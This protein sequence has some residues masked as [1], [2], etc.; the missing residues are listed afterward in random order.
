MR[1]DAIPVPRPESGW[2]VPW[3]ELQRFAWIAALSECPQ[4]PIHHAEGNV[5][6]H[7]RMVLEE[8]AR[9]VRW[10]TLSAREREI[11][12]L[13]AVLHD[14]AK[15]STT[16]V[17]ESGR[18]S[19]RGHSRRGAIETRRILWEM[20]Y[21]FAVR[22][23][24]CALVKYHQVPFFLIDE[25]DAMAR[26]ARIS[27]IARCD[28][29]QRVAAAD[30]RGRI[31]ADAERLLHNI[32]LFGLF[33]E[34]HGCLTEP[35]RFASEHARFRYFRDPRRDPGSDVYDDTRCEVVLMC[36]LPGAGKNHWIA[37]HVPELPVVSMDRIRAA[38]SIAPTDDQGAVRKEALEQARG[39]LR[40]GQSFVWNATNLDAQ[41]RDQ[42]IRL[43][44]DYR[45]RVR[46]VYVE[47]SAERLLAQNRSRDAVVPE[48]V[49]QSM[50]RMWQVP[51]PGEAHRVDYVIAED[52][53][54]DA[55]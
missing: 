43:F 3:S 33:A 39:Y 24:V 55:G 49:I 37:A 19:A 25:T 34:E 1:S 14:V 10:R 50:M 23:A 35:L 28:L 46:I 36:G 48:K 44:D 40:Q 53:E 4:D 8:L 42:L 15:P 27:Q 32:E 51:D 47:A 2:D 13:A 5:W 31:A 30:M 21:P 12:Y 52:Q 9:D 16:I 22:E 11:V 17:E 41:R 26:L 29:L 7:T 54:P 20:G 6:I 38:R 18:V 45:A